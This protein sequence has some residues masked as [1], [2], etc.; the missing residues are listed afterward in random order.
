MLDFFLLSGFS[1]GPRSF[2]EIQQRVSWAERLLVIAA[3]KRGTE[4]SGSLAKAIK[5]L[6]HEG[7]LNS[8]APAEQPSPETTY[9]LTEVRRQRLQEERERRH[10][11]VS[12]FVE[13]SELDA[14]GKPSPKTR[15]LAHQIG[16][17]ISL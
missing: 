13:N 8:E 7:W 17:A 14:S 15:I 4:G 16:T 3:A 5:R 1:D 2:V 10:G 9:S 11:M 6:L 12:Q